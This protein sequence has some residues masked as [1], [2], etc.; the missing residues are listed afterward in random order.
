MKFYLK[1]QKNRHTGYS[2]VSLLELNTF[3]YDNYIIITPTDLEDNDVRI[4]EPFDTIKPIENI[5][6]QIEET[7]EYADAGRA[8]YNTNQAISRSYL[9]V[10]N[11]GIYAYTCRE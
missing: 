9:L 8:Q 1:G 5:F 6:E 2:T 11:T 10:Q 4:R 3:L 7:V